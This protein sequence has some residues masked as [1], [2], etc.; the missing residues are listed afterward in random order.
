MR[1][2]SAIAMP[3]T[4]RPVAVAA[5]VCLLGAGAAGCS[6][7]QE[8]AEVQAA[9]AEHI[10][11]ARAEREKAKKR[12]KPARKHQH[13]RADGPKTGHI[14]RKSAHRQGGGGEG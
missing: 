10:L 8:K 7:T 12:H 1:S 5:C 13:S 3:R 6:T 9:K 4:M 14:G 2:V 11:N